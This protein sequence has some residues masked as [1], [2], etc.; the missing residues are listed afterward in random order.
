[1][2]TARFYMASTVAMYQLYFLS[3]KQKI[4][5]KR[6]LS[7]RLIKQPY[8]ECQDM[9][10]SLSDFILNE[11]KTNK[12]FENSNMIFQRIPLIQKKI[13]AKHHQ[14]PIRSFQRNYEHTECL[15]KVEQ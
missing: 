15:K 2:G 14:H 3:T 8:T 1:M 6:Y 11:S 10:K 4:A 9:A 12:R 13:E 7:S 5:A